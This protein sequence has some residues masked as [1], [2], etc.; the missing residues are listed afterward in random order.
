[1]DILWAIMISLVSPL[2][3]YASVFLTSFFGLRA[4]PTA[5]AGQMV[6]DK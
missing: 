4:D 2:G 1:M 6:R 5:R 3:C